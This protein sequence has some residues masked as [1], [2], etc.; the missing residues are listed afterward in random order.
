MV[1]GTEAPG[2]GTAILNPQTGKPSDD[3]LAII[4]RF[5]FLTDADKKID[6]SRQSAARLSV[7]EG[8]GRAGLRTRRC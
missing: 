4:D 7:A 2:S 5:D 1:F 6:G 3:V 8:E